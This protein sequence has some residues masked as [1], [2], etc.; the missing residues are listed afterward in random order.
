M[1]FENYDDLKNAHHKW[2]NSAMQIDNR[3][4]EKKVDAK[5]CCREQ[6]VYCEDKTNP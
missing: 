2:V 3:G 6:N 5:H 4:N 1:G